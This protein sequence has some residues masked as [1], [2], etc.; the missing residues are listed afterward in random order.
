MQVFVQAVRERLPYIQASMAP[1]IAAAGWES[2]R[3]SVDHDRRGP[4]WNARRI[5]QGIAE[6]GRP[7]VVLQDDVVLRK[8]IGASVAEVMLHIDSGRM[9]AVSLFAPPRAV[10]RRA[11]DEGHNFVETFDF[12]WAQGLL[13]TPAF[14]AGL[15]EFSAGMTTK[16]D[17]SVM[18][19]YSVA[20]G[21]PVFNCLP[22][23]VQHDLNLK[24]TLGTPKSLLGKMRRSDVWECAPVPAGHFAQVRAIRQGRRG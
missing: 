24:S 8:G 1:A 19:D 14:C 6:S 22:S 2:P 7:A 17:D 3:L 18:R 10:M 9:Q 11:Y 20:K 21:V 12:L 23:L 5:W 13:L 16:H 4:L 15:V